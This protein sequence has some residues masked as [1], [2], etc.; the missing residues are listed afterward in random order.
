MQ[1]SLYLRPTTY[2]WTLECEFDSLHMQRLITVNSFRCNS[3]SKQKNNKLVK[4][5]KANIALPGKIQS[6]VAEANT[7]LNLSKQ[8]NTFRSRTLLATGLSL[9]IF[10]TFYAGLTT[11]PISFIIGVFIAPFALGFLALDL[12]QPTVRGRRTAKKAANCFLKSLKAKR[13]K[14]AFACIHP[15]L[16]SK[17]SRL[18]KLLVLEVMPEEVNLSEFSG[19]KQYWKT[20][21]GMRIPHRDCTKTWFELVDQQENTS[22]AQCI[23][24][25]RMKTSGETT[26][27][28]LELRLGLYKHASQWWIVPGH[29]KEVRDAV[30]HSERPSAFDFLGN[31]AD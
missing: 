23:L 11:A 29:P 24:Y 15:E 5:S 7:P 31:I 4:Y 17:K 30:K 22:T 13:W 10:G 1:W 25:V 2:S 27:V 6:L 9:G 18:P 28:P 12:L 14:N 19:F 16:L 20:I 3:M 8:P 21:L 26:R